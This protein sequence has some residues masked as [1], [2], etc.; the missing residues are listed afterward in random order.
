M[1]KRTYFLANPR[2]MTFK[3]SLW[4]NFRLVLYNFLKKQFFKGH[5]FNILLKRPGVLDQFIEKSLFDCRRV[6]EK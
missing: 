1:L 2:A 4:K 3:N 5:V 6:L